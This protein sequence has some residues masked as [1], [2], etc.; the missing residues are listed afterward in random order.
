MKWIRFFRCGLAV[1][2]VCLAP[3]SAVANCWWDTFCANTSRAIGDFQGDPGKAL[4][5]GIAHIG[6]EFSDHVLARICPGEGKKGGR[7]VIV[8]TRKKPDTS[9]K[10][11]EK[12]RPLI[13]TAPFGEDTINTAVLQVNSKTIWVIQSE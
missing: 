4:Q 8:I 13:P 3:V 2:A 5:E 10:G 1:T 12:T 6:R 7:K 11:R 9:E